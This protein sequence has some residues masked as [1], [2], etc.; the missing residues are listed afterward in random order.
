M[1]DKKGPAEALGFTF[2]GVALEPL[3]GSFLRLS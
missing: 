1:T 3:R 2:T